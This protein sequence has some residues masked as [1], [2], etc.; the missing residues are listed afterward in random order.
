MKTTKLFRSLSATALVLFAMASAK[1]S[2]TEVVTELTSI[3]NIT[4]IKVSGNVELFLVQGND[5][6]VKVYED[7]FG[8]NALVQEEN[9]L[10]RI[11]SFTKEKLTVWVQVTD[12]STIEAGGTA[13]IRSMNKLSA[14]N[15]SINL[16]DLATA[17]LDAQAAFLETT[18]S[19]LAKLSL[20]GSADNQTLTIADAGL[21]D[22][23]KFDAQ[24]NTLDISA[25]GRLVSNRSQRFPF[26]RPD[27]RTIARDI[28]FH[29]IG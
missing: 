16:Q 25:N 5:V 15:L 20:S 13:N 23:R 10:L 2:A 6:Q 1:V 24:K 7:Y 29:K 26:E 9:G 22:V 27:F 28:R 12:L 18:V 8:K 11:S 14:V 19:D 21:V 4:G 3:K 17:S